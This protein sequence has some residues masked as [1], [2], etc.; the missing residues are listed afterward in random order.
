M[1]LCSAEYSDST[2]HIP[3]PNVIYSATIRLL[4]KQLLAKDRHFAQDI[5]SK[6]LALYVVQIN[7]VHVNNR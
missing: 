5:V 2:R 1:P 6:Y 4:G 7:H 3:T